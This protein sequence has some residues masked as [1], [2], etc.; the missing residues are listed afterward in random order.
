[1]TWYRLTQALK[2]RQPITI[3]GPDGAK[4][5]GRVQGIAWEG[6]ENGWIVQI[7]TAKRDG[8]CGQMKSVYVKTID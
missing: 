8:D 4:H 5:T 6:S 3:T 7:H 1:M 2:T